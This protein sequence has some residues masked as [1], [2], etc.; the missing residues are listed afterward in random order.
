MYTCI[1]QSTTDSASAAVVPSGAR[2]LGRPAAWA[3]KQDLCTRWLASR[4]GTDA[5]CSLSQQ[6]SSPAAAAACAQP[7]R[8]QGST[9]TVGLACSLLPTG[10]CNVHELLR[11]AVYPTQLHACS[12]LSCDFLIVAGNGMGAVTRVTLGPFTWFSPAQQ[13]RR[14]S[15]LLGLAYAAASPKNLNW[16]A[17]VLSACMRP[18]PNAKLDLKS[19]NG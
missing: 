5:G 3:C 6:Q 15:G 17:I 18:D 9:P 8:G 2:S 10:V 12:T 1:I 4:V 16:A 19:T 7:R 11:G 14:S 13:T